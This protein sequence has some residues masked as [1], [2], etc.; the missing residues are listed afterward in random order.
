MFDGI[1]RTAAAQEA[2]ARTMIA[3]NRWSEAA[4]GGA[5]VA[6]RTIEFA[7]DAEII[8]ALAEDRV[9]AIDAKEAERIGA[10]R[11]GKQILAMTRA[12]CREMNI[13]PQRQQAF[14]RALADA[15]RRLVR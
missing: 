5:E 8:L 1:A 3:I 9:A 7:L 13:A 15:L 12:H 14:E 6:M 2:R 4:A 10:S 11:L